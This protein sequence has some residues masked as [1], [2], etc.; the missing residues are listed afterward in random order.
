MLGSRFWLPFGFLLIFVNMLYVGNTKG[1]INSLPCYRVVN[2]KDKKQT[3]KQKSM[4][5]PR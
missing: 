2:K 1:R 3:N 4:K 5:D